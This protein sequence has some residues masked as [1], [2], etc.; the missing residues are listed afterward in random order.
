LAFA[1]QVSVAFPAHNAHTAHQH[2]WA[3][4]DAGT[5]KGSTP[6]GTDEDGHCRFFLAFCSLDSVTG[7]EPPVIALQEIP[8]SFVTLAATAKYLQ[9]N[10]ATPA[11][12]PPVLS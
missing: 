2:E 10:Y 11:R 4:G 8:Y 6:S 7:A 9:P 5:A 12:G 1:L 3:H